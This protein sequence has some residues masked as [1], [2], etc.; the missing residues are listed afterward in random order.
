MREQGLYML[1]RSRHWGLPQ[2]CKPDPAPA[3]THPVP[4]VC[5]CLG[6]S[7]LLLPSLSPIHLWLSLLPDLCLSITILAAGTGAPGLPPPRL[8][9]VITTSVPLSAVF[10][11]RYWDPWYYRHR[12]ERMASGQG[13]GFLEAIFSFVFGDGDPNADYDKRRWQMVRAEGGIL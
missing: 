10:A 2:R 7:S 13:M 11:C 6:L 5:I 12:R 1:H 3:C 4:T 9:P 8:L